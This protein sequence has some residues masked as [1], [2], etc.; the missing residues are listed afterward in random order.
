MVTLLFELFASTTNSMQHYKV[1]RSYS[2]RTLTKIRNLIASPT[3][4]GSFDF[5]AHTIQTVT[6]GSQLYA[7]QAY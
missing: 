2:S 7:M 6:H 5:Q 4:L 3:P 1:P